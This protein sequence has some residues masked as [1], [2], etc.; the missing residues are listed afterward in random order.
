MTLWLSV[1]GLTDV[2]RGRELNEDRFYYKVVQS[3]EEGSLGLFIVADGMGGHLAGEVA[4][5]WTV[6]TLKRELGPLF[7]PQDPSVTRRLDAEALIAVGSGVTVRLDETDL[8]RMLEHAVERANQ[9]LL[10]YARK[11]SDE[12]ADM[13]ST[14]TLAV[15]EGNRATIASVGDSRAYLWRNGWL[16]Q[17]TD[18][19]SVP[20]ALL[21]QG[22]ITPEE[23]DAHPH[24]HV[25]YR[26]VGLKPGVEVDIYPS[27]ALRHGDALLLCSDGL[28]DM[29]APAEKLATFLTPE[30]SPLVT[31][32]RMVD[33]ANEAG[34]EDN[35]TVVLVRAEDRDA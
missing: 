3:S 20:G 8:A 10:G 12:A 32:R 11:H 2:G 28:W 15:V 17:L 6:K 30:T 26:A 21:R 25:L 1:A 22:Q 33:A 4:S 31:C 29:L 23:A 9:V 16:R 5:Q 24:R 27:L 14:L 7:R 19:H 34:G 35:I 13:G 18:D